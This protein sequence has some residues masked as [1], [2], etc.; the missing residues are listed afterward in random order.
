MKRPIIFVTFLFILLLFPCVAGAQTSTRTAPG[1][2]TE[3]EDGSPA[4]RCRKYKFPNSSLTDNADGS[5]SITAGGT[6]L[7]DLTI[8]KADPCIIYD[9]TTATDT[10]FWTAVIDDAGSDDDDFFQIGD[11]TTCGTNPFFTIDTSGNVGIGTTSPAATL[12][13]Q[14]ASTGAMI[15]KPLCQDRHKQT[16]PPVVFPLHCK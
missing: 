10:D 1:Q 15:L 8:N 6:L 11:G 5:C 13:V 14:T 16:G 12:H 2:L 4:L 9:V 7:S 3:E